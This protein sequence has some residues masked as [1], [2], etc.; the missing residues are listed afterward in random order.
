MSSMGFLC[1]VLH[2]SR[3]P[4]ISRSRSTHGLVQTTGLGTDGT[5]PARW[6]HARPIP[7]EACPPESGVH[8]YTPLLN[9][10][11]VGSLIKG[12]TM[13]IKWAKFCS[14]MV[15]FGEWGVLWLRIIWK[16]SELLSILKIFRVDY[17]RVRN[18]VELKHF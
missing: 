14:S 11:N 13:K 15:L 10:P 6:P 1:I 3:I 7:R 4:A 16:C 8:Q 2:L 18:R 17:D 12:C 9:V 5:Y